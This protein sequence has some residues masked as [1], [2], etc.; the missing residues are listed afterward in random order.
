MAASTYVWNG[1]GADN[2]WNTAGNW[3]GTTPDSDGTA[4]LQFDGATRLTP[5]AQDDYSLDSITFNAGA[6]AFTLG[7]GTLTLGAGGLVQNSAN[8]Q[9]INNA[10]VLS[11]GQTWAVNAGALDLGGTLDGSGDLTK[12]GGGTLTFNAANTYTGATNVVEGTLTIGA[13]GSINNGGNIA[14]GSATFNVLGSV[15]LADGGAL[16]VDG[17]SAGPA[18]V[19]LSGDAGAL[20]ASTETVGQVGVGTFNHGGGTN[21]VGNLVIGD[22]TDARGTYNLSGTGVLSASSETLANQGSG[23]F[24]QNGGT[25]SVDGVIF[26]AGDAAAIGVYNLNGGVL[27]ASNVLAGPGTSVFNFNGGTLKPSPGVDSF[28]L[29]PITANVQAGGARI[30]YDGFSVTVSR[31]L[32][33]DAALGTSQDG[34]LTKLGQG[35]LTL[36]GASTFTGATVINAGS[37]TLDSGKAT[38]PRLA[39]TSGIVMNNGGS[40]V[41]AQNGSAT[42]TDRINDAATVTL[43]GGTLN[44][45]GLSEGAAGT[46]G[47]GALTLTATSTLDFGASGTNNLIQ[48]AGVGAHTAGAQLQVAEWEGTNGS[49]NGADRLLFAGSSSAFT[50]LYSQSDVSFNGVVGYG[51]QNYAGYYEVFGV[52]DVPEPTTVFAGIILVGVAGWRGRKAFAWFKRSAFQAA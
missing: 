32:L 30:D 16:T 49:P 29:G 50:T 24:N 26:L 15:A 11:A 35:D 22:G 34:G 17:A 48:F 12:T 6:G 19:S 38:T 21:T 25:H 8:T 37:L 13:N 47:V 28:L 1:A 36:T 5:V 33:H 3:G 14:V 20:S 10:V 9:T 51:V 23:T 39:G 4:D 18:L 45:G 42:S 44:L 27:Q 40:L 41:L 46:N 31:P 43:A 2:N 52:V 7:G